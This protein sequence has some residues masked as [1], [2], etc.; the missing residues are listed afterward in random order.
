MGK[1]LGNSHRSG[2]IG[3]GAGLEAGAGICL[4]GQQHL[5]VL[6]DLPLQRLLEIRTWE[7]QT[8]TTIRQSARLSLGATWWRDR[9]R[10]LKRGI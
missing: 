8:H 2:T 3:L 4:A 10:Q 7:G 6:R 1:G 5:A 9:G